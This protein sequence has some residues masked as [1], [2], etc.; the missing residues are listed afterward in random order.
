MEPSAAR[1]C[2]RFP[3]ACPVARSRGL[4]T[5]ALAAVNLAGPKA[6]EVLRQLTTLDLSAA[7]FPYP[8]LREA[9]VAGVPCGEIN[10]IDQVFAAPQVKHL[11]LAQTVTS[12][13]RGPLTLIGQPIKLS[14]SKSTFRKAPPERGEHTDEILAE[15]GYSKA[16]IAALR[17]EGVL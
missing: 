2:C 17:T 13:A 5:S 14:R 8:A 16:E 11:G 10:S 12:R 1:P 15:F 3:L 9:N 6:R 4:F 7:T